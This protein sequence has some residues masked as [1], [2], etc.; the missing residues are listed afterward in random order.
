MLEERHIPHR[1]EAETLAAVER[2]AGAVDGKILEI[3]R[4]AGCQDGGEDVGRGV[5]DQ[6]A[7]GVGCH[8]L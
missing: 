5:I 3:L 4:A 2:G 6:V 7:P 8:E 1:A